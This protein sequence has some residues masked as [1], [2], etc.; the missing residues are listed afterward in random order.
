[1]DRLLTAGVFESVDGVGQ[2]A[3]T[4]QKTRALLLV[5][6]LVVPHTDGDRVSLADVSDREE[7]AKKTYE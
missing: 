5:D 4:A 7:R 3:H 2:E 6:L 1:M